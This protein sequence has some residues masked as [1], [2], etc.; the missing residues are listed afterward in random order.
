L[1]NHCQKDIHLCPWSKRNRKNQETYRKKSPDRS[2]VVSID[3]RQF[4][5]LCPASPS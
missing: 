2:S 3:A 1:R 5:H 4:I